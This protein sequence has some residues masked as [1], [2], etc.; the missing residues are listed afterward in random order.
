MSDG[1]ITVDE[2]RE[3]FAISVQIKDPRL[4]R[5][6]TAAGRQM[7]VWVGDAA[8]DDALLDNPTDETRKADL[9]LAEA[10]L[11]MHYAVLGISTSLRAAG[12]VKTEKED[13]AVV[14]SYLS[15]DEVVKLQA[16]YFETAR[17]LANPYLVL[18]DVVDDVFGL[19]VDGGDRQ[20]EA[21]TRTRTCC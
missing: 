18:E 6:L 9:E 5:H 4:E 10:H 20:C 8:Y 13:N 2:L 19:L 14:T 12:T 3:I 16:A 15:P 11:A 21:V 7:R 1:L 17:S